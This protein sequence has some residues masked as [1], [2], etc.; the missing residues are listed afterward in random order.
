MAFVIPGAL[1]LFTVLLAVL[2]WQVG[3]ILAVAVIGTL[4]VLTMHWRL[5]A[6]RS[7]RK[8]VYDTHLRAGATPDEAKAKADKARLDWGPV[9]S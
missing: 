5:Q 6:E 8:I 3:V 9:D 7:W 4:F 1:L 2:P